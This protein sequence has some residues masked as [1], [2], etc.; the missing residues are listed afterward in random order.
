MQGPTEMCPVAPR[1][2]RHEKWVHGQ[3]ITHAASLHACSACALQ[4]LASPSV[5]RRLRAVPGA[6]IPTSPNSL[7]RLCPAE[8][9][10]SDHHQWPMDERRSIHAILAALAPWRRS[11]RR[12]CR[13]GWGEADL[14]ALITL[15][16][17]VR[18]PSESGKGRIVRAKTCVQECSRDGFHCAW[19][20]P[21]L[22]VLGSTSKPWQ[23]LPGS[24]S[25]GGCSGISEKSLYASMH[26]HGPK[27]WEGSTCCVWPSSSH[28]HF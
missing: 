11:I 2:Q 16:S 14:R 23:L 15:F 8:R 13:Q 3:S 22:W 10:A 20:Q 27:P 21:I 26:G 9:P 7:S 5:W 28:P 12:G 6:W 17:V 4:F 25:R 19:L 24:R 18:L 1:L